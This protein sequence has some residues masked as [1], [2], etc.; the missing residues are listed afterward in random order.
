MGQINNSNL[1]F[2]PKYT[3]KL[4]TNSV[5]NYKHLILVNCMTREWKQSCTRIEHHC[6]CWCSWTRK[7]NFLWQINTVSATVTWIGSYSHPLWLGHSKI[8]SF[9]YLVKILT[10]RVYK[11]LTRTNFWCNFSFVKLLFKQFRLTFQFWQVNPSFLGYQAFSA[12]K[13]IM[14]VNQL[15]IKELNDRPLAKLDCLGSRHSTR[16]GWT[17]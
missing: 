5:F 6:K 15:T 7:R 14:D 10:I 2:R 3:L 11:R 9:M 16:E 1:I 13:E 8:L 17:P 12:N 4:W